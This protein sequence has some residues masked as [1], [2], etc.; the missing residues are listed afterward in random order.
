V[1]L[2]II[3]GKVEKRKKEKKKNIYMYIY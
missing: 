3:L 1:R 2:R